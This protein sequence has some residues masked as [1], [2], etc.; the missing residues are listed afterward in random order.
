MGILEKSS[1]TLSV[2]FLNRVTYVQDLVRE[3]D[4]LGCLGQ[5]L[6]ET[7]SVARVVEVVGGRGRVNPVG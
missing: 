3:R 4:L 7:L 6:L 2:Q 5:S 1:Y